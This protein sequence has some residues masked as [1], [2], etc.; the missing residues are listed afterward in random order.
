MNSGLLVGPFL[1]GI[2]YDIA[3]YHAVFEVLLGG[4]AFDFLLRL[5]MIEKQ[6]VA[7]QATL[8]ASSPPNIKSAARPQIG[9]ISRG[10]ATTCS[11]VDALGDRSHEETPLLHLEAVKAQ[12]WFTTTFPTMTILVHSPRFMAAVGG[13][14]TQTM[15][16][17][18]F[19]PI[20]PLFVHRTFGWGPTGS[21]LIFLAI[22]L[23][24]LLGSL[25]GALSDAY[26]PKSVSL[27]GFAIS[28][29]SLAALSA[30]TYNATV[31]KVLLCVLLTLVGKQA[32]Q[33]L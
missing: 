19:D 23:P 1:G 27:I 13:S 18:A 8:E 11:K 30:I 26:G 22:S 31:M 5:A 24:S 20:L 21:G 6:S 4:L 17:A 16:V 33:L 15:L 29:P 28:I 32:S 25:A 9:N 3:G 12:N 2:I 14:F 7:P 10:S